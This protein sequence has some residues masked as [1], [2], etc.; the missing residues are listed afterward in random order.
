MASILLR[1]RMMM[2]THTHTQDTFQ[3]TLYY[4]VVMMMMC[5]GLAAGR[6]F[7]R[8]KCSRRANTG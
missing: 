7:P 6:W 4:V 3:L 2:H 5:A 1:T 8:C